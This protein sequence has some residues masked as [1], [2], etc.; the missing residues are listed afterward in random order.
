MQI[1]SVIRLTFSFFLL[2]GIVSCSRQPVDFGFD[3]SD[4]VGTWETRGY[5]NGRGTITYRIDGTF[6]A[7]IELYNPPGPSKH[8]SSTGI[9]RIDGNRLYFQTTSCSEET[10]APNSGHDILLNIYENRFEYVRP[11]ESDVRYRYRVKQ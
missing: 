3:Q 9:W 2:I 5:L 11:G 4:L 6:E 1:S 7:N 10:S 8:V